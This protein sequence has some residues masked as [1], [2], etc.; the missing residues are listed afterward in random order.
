LQDC[1]FHDIDVNGSILNDYER[2]CYGI[3]SDGE[4]LLFSKEMI[5]IVYIENDVNRTLIP[6]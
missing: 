2:G 3:V 1:F 5:K 6:L 4:H